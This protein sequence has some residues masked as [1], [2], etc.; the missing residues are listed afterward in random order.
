MNRLANFRPAR[1][2][3][4]GLLAVALVLACQSTAGACPMCKEALNA[5]GGDLV[6]GFFYS[7][8]FMLSMPFLIF[9]GLSSYLYLLVRRARNENQPAV[10]EVEEPVGV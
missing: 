8:L 2:T 9:A 3:L 10:A 7:I 4:M 1:Q 6:S 5:N